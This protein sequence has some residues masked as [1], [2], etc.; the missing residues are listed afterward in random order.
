MKDHQEYFQLQN[1]VM[2][3]IV[4]ERFDKYVTYASQPLKYMEMF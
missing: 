1:Y 2:L 4:L 3:K